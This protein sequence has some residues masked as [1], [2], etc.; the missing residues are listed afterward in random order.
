ML[1]YQIIE[2]GKPLQKVINDTPKPKGTEVLM[3]ITRSGVCHS[4]LHAWDGY[5]DLGGGERFYLKE[6]IRRAD[7]LGLVLVVLGV[8][9]VVLAR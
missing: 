9:I 5:F 4:D 1:S 2:H 8:V 6:R 3:R 7:M